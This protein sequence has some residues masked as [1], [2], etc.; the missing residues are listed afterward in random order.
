M[1]NSAISQARKEIGK[2]L[3][4]AIGNELDTLSV[5]RD[6]EEAVEMPAFLRLTFSRSLRQQE[7]DLFVDAAQTGATL[8]VGYLI[9]ACPP[10]QLPLF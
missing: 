7:L 4:E 3:D 2:H 9:C 6:S 8:G 5:V 1:E 10:T